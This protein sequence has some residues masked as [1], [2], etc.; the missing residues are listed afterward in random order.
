MECQPKKIRVAALTSGQNIP[1]RRFRVSQHI[2]NLKTYNIEVT[3]HCPVVNQHARLPGNLSNIR[4]RYLP[5]LLAS[6]ILLNSLC[7]IPGIIASH[8]AQILWLE[9][10]FV[11]GFE[12]MVSLTKAPRI[13]DVDDAVWLM[14]PLGRGSAKALAR[15]MNAVVAGNSFLADWYSNYCSRV[16]V[17]PTAIDCQQ[18]FLKPESEDHDDSF[19][20]GWTGTAGNFKYLKMIE[21]ALARFLTNFPKARL[22]ILAEKRPHFEFV[23]QDKVEFM[24]WSAATEASGLHRM[25]VGIMPLEDDDWTRGKCS[26]KMLQYMA[27]GLPV[28]VSPVGMNKEV[29]QRGLFGFSAENNNAWYQYLEALYFDRQLRFD[30]GRVGRS[31]VEKNYDVRVVSSQLSQI[32]KGLV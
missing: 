15:S 12:A 19:V 28:I 8:K 26:F 14:N 22:L 25:D 1:S 4:P 7:R 24:P 27:V 17:V 32:M 9:R 2:S 20:I 30:L 21:K 10:S 13:L 5:P 16:H 29:L 18:F 31:V 6:Q 3:E 11:P 23:A